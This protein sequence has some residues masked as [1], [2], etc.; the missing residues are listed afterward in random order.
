MFY[1][2]FVRPDWTDQL[3]FTTRDGDSGKCNILSVGIHLSTNESTRMRVN[4]E[5]LKQKRHNSV[6]VD[7]EFKARHYMV[8]SCSEGFT[9]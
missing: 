2:S 7:G 3:T 6:R 9:E 4:N 1:F 8:A 5:F